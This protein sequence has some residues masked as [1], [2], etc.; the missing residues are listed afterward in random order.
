MW[1]VRIVAWAG[2]RPFSSAQAGGHAAVKMTHLQ[3]M[4][5]VKMMRSG[6]GETEESEDAS[7]VSSPITGKMRCLKEKRQVRIGQVGDYSV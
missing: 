5:K 4:L 7:G 6:L 1:A 3:Q 2:W